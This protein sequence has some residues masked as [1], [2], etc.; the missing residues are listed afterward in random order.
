MHTISAA[1]C[2]SDVHPVSDDTALVEAARHDPAAF[3][4]LYHR[5]FDRVYAY[6]RARTAGEDDAADLTQQVF[7]QSPGCPAPLPRPG[8]RLRCVAVPHRPEY[9]HGLPPPAAR[10]GCLGPAARSLAATCRAWR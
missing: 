2:D 4:L 9:R 6:L 8:R 10:H 7:L 1:P 3:G 5:Y